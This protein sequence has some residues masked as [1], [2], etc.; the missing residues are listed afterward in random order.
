MEEMNVRGSIDLMKLENA[1]VVTLT[2]KTG[3]KKKGLFVPIDD[4]DIYV[5]EDGGKAKSAYF[6]LLVN[7]RREV[8]QYG[9]THYAK[10]SLSR[11]F[12]DSHKELAEKKNGIYLGDFETYVVESGN[13]AA[14]VESQPVD[15]APEEKDDLPF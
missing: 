9:K 12:R 2:G 4:N 14:K 8:S 13:A 6:G 7:Q 10:Q 3:V 5:T 11:A 15:L 1:C